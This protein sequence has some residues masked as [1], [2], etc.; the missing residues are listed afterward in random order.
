MNSQIDQLIDEMIENHPSPE[1]ID[2]DPRL[3]GIP[4]ALIISKVIFSF[5]S[6]KILDLSDRSLKDEGIKKLGKVL[7]N[8]SS[9]VRICLRGNSIGNKGALSLSE[10][11]KKNSTITWLDLSYNWLG[12]PS[13]TILSEALKINESLLSLNLSHNVLGSEGTAGIS[14]GLEIN[15]SLTWLNLATNCKIGDNGV[16]ALCNSL[17][18]NKSLRWLNLRENEIGSL[19]CSALA[20]LILKNDTIDRLWLGGN[21]LGDGYRGIEDFGNA[22]SS[23]K[24]IRSLDLA[25]N[26]ISGLGLSLLFNGLLRNYTLRNISLTGNPI[27]KKGVSELCLLIELNLPLRAI[28][29]DKEQV[30]IKNAEKL[31]EAIQ[32]NENLIELQIGWENDFVKKENHVKK[33]INID[34]NSNNDN[35]NNNN[36]NNDNDINNNEKKSNQ[37][38][39]KRRRRR[40]KSGNNNDDEFC[41]KNYQNR[42]SIYNGI[43]KHLSKNDNRISTINEDFLQLY[44]RSELTNIELVGNFAHKEILELRIGEIN[45]KGYKKRVSLFTSIE[46]NT[47]LK[48]VYSDETSE[49]SEELIEI[50]ANKI[51]GSKKPF[52]STLKQ[53]LK[54]LYHSNE[55]KDFAVIVNGEKIFAHR[56]VLQARSGLFRDLFTNVKNCP[57]HVSDYYGS[58]KETIKTFFYYLYTNEINEEF[59]SDL[60]IEQLHD[61]IDYYQLNENSSI[62]DL[63]ELVSIKR[64]QI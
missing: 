42:L 52:T 19:G 3:C 47:F 56:I 64:F 50:I 46:M 29:L 21:Q 23:N 7:M 55:T 60:A 61:V 16:S 53:D 49:E 45:W 22:L 63:I 31:L 34:N 44:R 12:P 14:P 43:K 48:W 38:K 39:K 15:K 28:V 10:V 26:C 4:S 32:S 62:N 57:N 40:R 20:E 24:T 25:W 6:L 5:Q 1:Q 37:K 58:A 27:G 18:K 9:L 17:I 35:D 41:K 36:N 2:F 54:Q 30:N 51:G 59:L 8:H 33:N 11:L 13:G